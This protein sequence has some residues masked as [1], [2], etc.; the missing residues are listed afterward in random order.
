MLLQMKRIRPEAVTAVAKDLRRRRIPEAEIKRQ[1][2]DANVRF[3]VPLEWA[4]LTAQ[5]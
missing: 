2:L 3:G 5:R 1:V 4:L